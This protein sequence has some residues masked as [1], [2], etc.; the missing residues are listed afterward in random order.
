MQRKCKKTCGTCNGP[1]KQELSR[2]S[3][4][5]PAP[6]QQKPVVSTSSGQNIGCQDSTDSGMCN[7]LK[8]NPNLLEAFCK[9][10]SIW[11]NCPVSCNKCDEVKAL[12]SLSSRKIKL[13]FNCCYFQFHLIFIIIPKFILDPSFL[14]VFTETNNQGGT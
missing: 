2:N 6:L 13:R 9:N 14:W 8:S 10:K 3:Q 11:M 5:Q 12:P 7:K 4:V 1:V